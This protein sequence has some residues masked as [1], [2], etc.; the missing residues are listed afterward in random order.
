[1]PGLAVEGKAQSSLLLAVSWIHDYTTMLETRM[2]SGDV[3]RD[4]VMAVS[5]DRRY[6]RSLPG[7]QGRPSERQLV[8]GNY[9]GQWTRSNA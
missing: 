6:P 8:R 4:W 1:M 9:V 7:G 3:G 2:R 5:A